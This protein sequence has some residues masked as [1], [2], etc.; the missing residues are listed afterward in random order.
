MMRSRR[1]F[2]FWIFDFGLTDGAGRTVASGGAGGRGLDE[3]NARTAKILTV[4]SGEG[5]W[6]FD[7]GFW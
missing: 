2:D 3:S 7:F 1:I 5:I 4:L 6:I